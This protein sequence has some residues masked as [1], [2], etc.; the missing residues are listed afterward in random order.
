MPKTLRA[1]GMERGVPLPRQLEGLGECHKLPSE[2]RDKD[3]AK[4]RVLVYLE[5]KK[6]TR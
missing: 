5:M 4:K 6:H 1:E 3:P 2:V